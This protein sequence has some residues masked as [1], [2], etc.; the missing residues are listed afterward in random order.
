MAPK[1]IP[2]WCSQTEKTTTVYFLY[3]GNFT[4][5]TAEE[6]LI[7]PRAKLFCQIYD[8]TKYT[9]LHLCAGTGNNN[10]IKH[11]KIN[12][13]HTFKLA[14]RH[15]SPQK[16]T[17]EE[18]EAAD[19]M[20]RFASHMRGHFLLIEAPYVRWYWG[21]VAP[22]PFISFNIWCSTLLIWMETGTEETDRGEDPHDFFCFTK[23]PCQDA[24]LV[25]SSFPLHRSA[26]SYSPTPYIKQCI[27]AK[28]L[29]CHWTWTQSVTNESSV[30]V[31]M[32]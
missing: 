10:K 5:V 32:V 24:S 7:H 15:N 25:P 6:N 31:F 8:N 11:I 3:I 26:H 27:Y 19:E 21:K 12:K 29:N 13:N 17:E 9:P 16:K 28:Q 14:N 30:F 20:I 1:Q 4:A 18:D 23:L 22:L 2:M